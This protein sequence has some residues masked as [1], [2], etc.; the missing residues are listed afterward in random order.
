MHIRVTNPYLDNYNDI[1]YDTVISI[2]LKDGNK[3]ELT[4]K[5][6]I[7]HIAVNAKLAITYPPLCVCM[8]Y[9]HINI[10]NTR[11]Y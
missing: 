4:V 8:I 11:I 3:Y 1:Y 5:S 2:S 7:H 10:I 6:T 9:E